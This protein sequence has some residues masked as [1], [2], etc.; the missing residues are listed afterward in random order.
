MRNETD[1]WLRFKKSGYGIVHIQAYTIDAIYEDAAVTH[2]VMDSGVILAIDETV[3]DVLE[4]ID[5]HWKKVHGRM[6]EEL[7]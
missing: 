3:D 4:A 1:S 6:K 7:E 2:L 5:A